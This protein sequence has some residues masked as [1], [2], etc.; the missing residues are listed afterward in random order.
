MI[1]CLTS[2]VIFEKFKLTAKNAT[3]VPYNLKFGKLSKANKKNIS[4]DIV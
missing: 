1:R 3:A 2:S 4:C